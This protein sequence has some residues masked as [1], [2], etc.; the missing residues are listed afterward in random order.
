MKKA[1][2]FTLVFTLCFN[3]FVYAFDYTNEQY[4]DESLISDSFTS[5]VFETQRTVRYTPWFKSYALQTDSHAA[6]GVNAGEGFQQIS[7]I[8]ISPIDRNL[9][10]F[11]TDTSGIWRSEDGGCT[12]FSVNKGVNC[13]GAHDIIF[14][15][16]KKNIVFMIQGGTN[17]SVPTSQ[18]QNRTTLDGL[19]KSTDG[20]KSW[21]QLLSVN[22]RGSVSTN[23]LIA[24]DSGENIY[25]LTS[26][27]LL[28]SEDEGAT[29]TT[30]YSFSLDFQNTDMLNYDLCVFDSTIVFTNDEYG[31]FASLDGGASWNRCN[32]NNSEKIPAYG[33]DINPENT[34][35][36]M[37][38][39]GG[40]NNG[41]YITT[42]AGTSWSLVETGEE[43]SYTSNKTPLKVL[44]GKRNSDGNRAIYL[45]YKQT[46]TPFRVSF[47]EGVTWSSAN[48]STVDNKSYL[49]FYGNAISLDP[50][51]ENVIYLGCGTLLKSTDSGCTFTANNTPG[52]T[53]A[54]VAGVEFSNNGDM[55]LSVVDNGLCKLTEHYDGSEY[56]TVSFIRP[57]NYSATGA[58]AVNPRN[59][60]HI[61]YRE[62]KND[63]YLLIESSDGGITWNDIPST[64]GTDGEPGFIKFHNND[65]DV[66]YSSFFSSYDGGETWVANSKKIVNVS[67]DNDIVYSIS[68]KNLYKSIDRGL[69]WSLLYSAPV[70]ISTIMPDLAESDKIWCGLLNGNV[71]KFS[72]T[73]SVVIDTS[74]GLSNVAPIAIAQNPNNLQHIVL[75]GQCTDYSIAN[76]DYYRNYNKTPGI[77]ETFDGGETWHVVKGMPSMRVVYSMKFSPYTDEIFIGG[78]TGGFIVYDYGV[79]KKYL[80]SNNSL[81]E[82]FTIVYNGATRKVTVSGKINNEN[83]EKTYSTLLVL[84]EETMIGNINMK[85]IAYL[86]Q[87]PV[88]ENG[89]FEYTFTMPSK[90]KYGQYSVYLGGSGIYLP[91]VGKYNTSEFRVLSFKFEEKQEVTAVARILNTTRNPENIVMY[92]VQYEN[93]G[94]DSKR[95]VDVKTEHYVI[96]G[97]ND[98]VIV[99]S[100]S[101]SIDEDTDVYRAFLW[102]DDNKLTPLTGYIENRMNGE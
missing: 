37:C 23:R 79:Y 54:Y 62:Y 69:S 39:F 7:D 63:G 60:N 29:W 38:C 87:I 73:E 56:P 47:D 3:M 19:Y 22:V 81:D 67:C 59:E 5:P 8:A 45:L 20:G 46:Y 14:H 99:K 6:T 55:Y 51:D 64:K 70:G 97:E 74:N 85:D 89:D 30:L 48:Y 65:E 66:I 61:L 21:E 31:V 91:G 26:E 18:I 49:P 88:S 24:F 10:I 93:V 90:C 25:F 16:T 13:W 42:N 72:E 76:N 33:I 52:Y 43:S 102:S 78:F 9:M 101:D 75:G 53:G 15:P 86:G 58:V 40:E 77:Y 71:V 27:G 50:I 68:G 98:D 96:A 44:Y 84:P 94:D 100:V 92:L 36:W 2:V 83:N 1:L 28:K 4:V 32:I 57:Q 34:N 12:W 11:G 17:S 95:L 41:L 82:N 35:V 80:T